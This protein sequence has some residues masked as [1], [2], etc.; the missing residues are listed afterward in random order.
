MDC[1]AQ[2]GRCSMSAIMNRSTTMDSREIADLIDSRHDKVK[3]SIERLA[4]RGVITL[5]PLGEV[6]NPGPGPKTITVY[7]F[8]GE[9]GKR[10]SIV[11]VAQMSP[12]FTARLVD[13]WQE[14]EAIVAGTAALQPLAK[15]PTAKEL[16]LLVIGESDRADRAEQRAQLEHTLRVTAESRADHLSGCV[17]ELLP[18]AHALEALSSEPGSECIT[19]CAKT[20]SVPPRWLF[21]YMQALEWIYKRGPRNAKDTEQIPWTMHDSA[22]KAGYVERKPGRRESK[23]ADGTAI[24]IPTNVVYVRRPGQ[25]KL[26]ELIEALRADGKEL[27]T[28]EELIDM[29]LSRLAAGREARKA[30]RAAKKAAAKA[31]KGGE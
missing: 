5:P 19:D 1:Q 24:Y 11:V 16:A 12:E 4:E 14:L 8:A 31:K 3:Q 10:D 29:H 13:R 22:W 17:D 18:K 15:L 9:K 28:K 2:R 30:Q 7:V 26:M 6:P 27:P 23:K 20:L 21:L 25:T